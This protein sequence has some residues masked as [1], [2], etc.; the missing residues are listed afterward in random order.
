VS[1]RASPHS[2]YSEKSFI[3]FLVDLNILMNADYLVCTFS[4]NV[5]RLAYEMR[6]RLFAYAAERTR[7]VDSIWYYSGL[8]DHQQVWFGQTTRLV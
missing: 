1:E 8:D 5:G 7:S 6:H 4:S 3:E 2:R